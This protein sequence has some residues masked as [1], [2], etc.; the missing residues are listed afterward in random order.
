MPNFKEEELDAMIAAECAASG[1]RQVAVILDRWL[2]RRLADALLQ[3][4]E[5]PIGI[6]GDDRETIDVALESHVS[7]SLRARSTGGHGACGPVGVPFFM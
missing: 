7:F 5:A 2:P 1:R 4:A 3:Q 6:R